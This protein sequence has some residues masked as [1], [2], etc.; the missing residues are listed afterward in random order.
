M[1][2]LGLCTGLLASRSAP[3]ESALRLPEPRS[4]GRTDAATWSED[5]SRLGPAAAS[6]TR[7]PDGHVAMAFETQIATGERS[8]LKADLAPAGSGLVRPV[9]QRSWRF[10]ADGS[11]VVTL[12]IDHAERR[13][14]CTQHQEPPQVLE[15]PELDRVANVPLNLLLLPL[16]E[17]TRQEMRYQFVLCGGRFRILDVEASV[18]R[19]RAVGDGLGPLTEVHSRFDLGFVL[20]ALAGPFLPRIVL[21]LDADAPNAWVGHSMPFTPE[22]PVIFVLRDDVSPA[23]LGLAGP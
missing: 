12:E 18:E 7:A 5:G 14:T 11:P 13:V 20:S 3:A 1:A 6:V 17:G 15:L 2:V 21:W 8:L 22:G 4:F 23:A 9:R 10:A 19:R 16:A